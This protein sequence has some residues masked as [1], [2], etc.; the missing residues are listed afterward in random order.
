MSQGYEVSVSMVTFGGAKP[1]AFCVAELIDAVRLTM[2]MVIRS[3]I[4][5]SRMS[6]AATR[7]SCRTYPPG[8]DL[9]T[10]GNSLV[11]YAVPLTTPAE[12]LSVAVTKVPAAICPWTIA[13]VELDVE[14]W[15]SPIR[16]D[17][18]ASSGSTD[19]GVA[20]VCICA[21]RGAGGR[22]WRRC[23]LRVG[24]GGDRGLQARSGRHCSSR[25]RRRPTGHPP[26]G[27]GQARRGRQVR[28]A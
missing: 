26:A 24:S 14:I 28:P 10:R 6:V 12:V 21:R 25:R 9:P 4:C 23:Q 19:L 16:R 3:G 11:L 27:A 22:R 1:V 5:I 13:G 15:G 17:H 7:P 2:G 20:A 8:R 18:G